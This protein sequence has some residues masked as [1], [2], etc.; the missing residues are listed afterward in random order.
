MTSNDFF[1]PRLRQEQHSCHLIG[2]HIWSG[3]LND[4]L[5]CACL[6]DIQM[7]IKKAEWWVP[8][9]TAV[10]LDKIIVSAGFWFRASLW[11]IIS[12]HEIILGTV[13]KKSRNFSCLFI[14]SQRGGSKPSNFA[15]LLVFIKLKTCLEVSLLKHADFSLTTGFSGPEKF[16][17]VSRKMPLL[18]TPYYS[19]F[20][21]W[22]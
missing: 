4:F 20:S 7:A 1:L 3:G 11:C 12:A 6:H 2:L 21:S 10:K 9:A 17:G 5:R 19:L 18:S 14:S 22:D 16:S 13:S 15:I 8:A